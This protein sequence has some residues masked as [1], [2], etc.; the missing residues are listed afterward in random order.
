MK[1]FDAEKEKL[2]REAGEDRFLQMMARQTIE[3]MEE[4]GSA[5]LVMEEDRTL[6][7]LKKIFDKFAGEHKNGKQAV[8]MPDEAAEMICDYYEIHEMKKSSGHLDIM[9]LL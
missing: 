9:D 6:A 7:D 1:M 5:G 3:I 2:N 4:K 8:I